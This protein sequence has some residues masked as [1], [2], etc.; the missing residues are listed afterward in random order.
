MTNLAQSSRK[1]PD[2][3]FFDALMQLQD[4]KSS[5]TVFSLKMKGFGMQERGCSQINQLSCTPCTPFVETKDDKQT[6]FVKTKDDK[7]TKFVK[8]K[9]DKQTK[10]VK[11]KDDKQT[12]APV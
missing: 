9:D 5:H 12:K 3:L 8:T 1:S 11:T 10:L 7:Q 6:K 4:L 2:P